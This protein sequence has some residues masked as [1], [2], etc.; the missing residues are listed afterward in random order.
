M[1]HCIKLIT[2]FLITFFIYG[3]G[4]DVENMEKVEKKKEL[5]KAIKKIEPKPGILIE[6]DTVVGLKGENLTYLQAY[7]KALTL[8]QIPLVEKYI[9]T[10][11]GKA[12]VIVTGPENGEPLVLLHGMNASST[13]WY[14]NIKSL[15]QQYR[16]YAIDFFLEPGKSLCQPEA[17]GTSEIVN[18]YYEIFDHLNLKKFSLVGASRGGW[19][20]LNI[21]LH[22][23]SRIN[24]IVLLSPAQ[25]FIWIRPGAK[26]LNN[27]EY[28][29]I[30]KRKR[31]RNVLETMTFDVDK[32]SQIYINQYY[33]AT[34]KATINK[35]FLQMRPF[36]DKQLKSLNMPILM[37]IGDHDIINNNKSINRAKEL[38]P[39]VE[40]GKIKNSGHFLSVDQ[41]EIVNK[42]ILDFLNKNSSFSEKK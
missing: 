36:S 11:F 30:P 3:C 42:R 14:P 34:K 1:K 7:D 40:T 25:T 6:K 15:S 41:P 9:K 26:I 16:V 12:H 28:S 37:L 38:F 18:W 22:N 31:L 8:W 19:L 20:A 17:S 35:C 33:I 5:P 39:N 27:I 23:K 29:M 10:T 32:I 24:K 4:S 2:L 21:A 13:M